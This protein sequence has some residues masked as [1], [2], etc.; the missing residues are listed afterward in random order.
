M[1]S[2]VPCS[3]RTP[4]GTVAG[5]PLALA[6]GVYIF[7]KELPSCSPGATWFR[8]GQL[9][10]KWHVGVRRPVIRWELK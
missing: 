7:N 4:P 5:R 9:R 10:R 1:K 6:A 3:A 8:R 2:Q